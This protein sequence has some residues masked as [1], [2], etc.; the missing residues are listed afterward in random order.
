MKKLYHSVILFV[1]ITFM[2][3]TAVGCSPAAYIIPNY[4]EFTTGGIFVDKYWSSFSGGK[5]VELEGQF[6]Q[7]STEILNGTEQLVFSM[8]VPNGLHPVE[9]YADRNFASQLY[10]LQ[11][12]NQI[13][14][15][16]QTMSLTSRSRING[17]VTGNHLAVQLEKLVVK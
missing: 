10:G 4:R 1:I 12:G 3:L 9:I 15:Y 16:G 8:N 13:V 7:I 11:Q 17:G 6:D 5:N 2:I 14:V